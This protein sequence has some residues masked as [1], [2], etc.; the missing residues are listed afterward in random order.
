MSAMSDVKNVIYLHSHDSGKY[1][2]VYDQSVS[3]PALDD[4]ANTALTF[5]RSFCC[6][7]TCSPS[8]SALVT[9]RYPHSNGMLGL[10]NR[11]FKLHDYEQHIVRQLN[12]KGYE[13]V[14]CGIQHEHGRYVHHEAGANAI[15]YQL[16]LTTDNEGLEEKELVHWDLNNAA[17]VADWLPKRDLSKPLFLSFGLFSTHREYPDEALNGESISEEDLVVPGFLVDVPE[18]RADLAAHQRSVTYYDAALAKVFRALREN[19]YFENSIIFVTSDHGIAFPQ[20]KC[21]LRDAGI[22]IPLLMH[23]PGS[24]AMGQRTSALMSHVDVLPTLFDLLGFEIPSYCQGI[25]QAA[26]FDDPKQSI[27]EAV[28]SEINFHTSYEPMRSV[29]TDKFKYIRYYDDNY[30]AFNLSNMD[31]SISKNYYIDNGFYDGEKT[32]E[33]LYD[34]EQDP[35]ESHNL[36]GDPSYASILSDLRKRLEDWMVKTDDPLVQGPIE[37]RENWRVNK[38]TA[39]DPKSKNPDD[40][41]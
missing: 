24:S 22:G 13:T 6:S 23:V 8:R 14:L 26:L 9:G 5:D 1:L 21:T 31:R 12:N 4:F 29:R 36:I 19:G 34:L 20:A 30:D 3:T 10:T 11:G 32:K 41:I 38:P 37:I 27:R 35:N 40:F 33:H 2:S 15:G 39:L 17:A 7:P 18:V 16:N 25:S 28:F